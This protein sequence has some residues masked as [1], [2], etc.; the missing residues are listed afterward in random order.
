VFIQ[1]ESEIAAINMVY[2]RHAG[3]PRHDFLFQSG[4]SLMQEG[5]L[6]SQGRSA[7]VLVDMMRGDRGWK[8]RPSPGR[9]FQL[10]KEADTAIIAHRVGACVHPRG[11]DL[12]YAR[13]TLR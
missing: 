2:G 8:Y 10:T 13:S 1:A 7:V 12:V 9:L 5:C 4:V 6:T 11:V 3:R